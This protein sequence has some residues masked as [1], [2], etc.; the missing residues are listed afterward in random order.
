MS[1][2]RGRQGRERG[3][4]LL[5]GEGERLVVD[6]QVCAGETSSGAAGAG[7]VLEPG[8]G[9]E[10]DALLA[11]READPEHLAAQVAVA[12]DDGDH[13][14]ERLVRRRE[15]VGGVDQEP[16][17]EQEQAGELADLDR[18]ALAVLA[19]LDVGDFEG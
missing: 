1:V 11:V 12:L 7:P 18:V 15:L 2:R 3:G 13:P 4:D 9:A 14:E 5:G 10:L 6:D 16:V 17:G 19:G 8:A